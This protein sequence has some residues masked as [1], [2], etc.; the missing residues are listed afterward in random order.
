MCRSDKKNIGNYET[1][2]KEVGAMR[3]IYLIRHGKTNN[4]HRCIGQTDIPLEQSAY[5]E[6]SE[7]KQNYPSEH[8]TVFSSPL[9]RTRQTAEILYDGKVVQLLPELAEIN[10]GQWENTDFDTIRTEWPQ[11][12]HA[13]GKHPYVT[14]APGGESY[15][16][17]GNRMHRAVMNLS[18]KE[19]QDLVMFT[20]SGCIKSLLCKLDVI[21]EKDFFK[22]EIPNESVTILEEENLALSVKA[23]GI[24][25]KLLTTESEVEQFYQHY[26]LSEQ[27]IAHMKA[28]ADYADELAVKV[29]EHGGNI[30]RKLLYQAALL[31]DIAR[32]EKRHPEV[33]AAYLR[34]KGYMKIADI[35][36]CHHD[37][38]VE[39]MT[40]TDEKLVLF[41]ADKRLRGDEKV[42]LEERFSSSREKCKSKEAQKMHAIRYEAAKYA[43]K[44]I[45]DKI[46]EE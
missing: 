18:R 46:G 34:K 20:H 45:K 1:V 11:L 21:E 25:P 36:E 42:S 10:M 14:V 19:K 8:V 37:L 28:V 9:T 39:D 44:L 6:L 27:I 31:H 26:A 38:K 23:T 22:T 40:E 3:N 15:R 24:I 29:N 5:T 17:V 16:E 7:M 12:Y 41:Y 4:K 33:A 35:I 13:R 2:L 43:E 30:N 32:V